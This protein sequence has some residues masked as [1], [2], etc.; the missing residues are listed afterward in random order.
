MGAVDRQVTK[1]ELIAAAILRAGDREVFI[2][3]RHTLPSAAARDIPKDFK[4]GFRP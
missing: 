3:D 2:V 4:L 1:E